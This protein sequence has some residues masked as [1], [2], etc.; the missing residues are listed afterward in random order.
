MA[1][2]PILGAKV[3]LAMWFVVKPG[4]SIAADERGARTRTGVSG[5]TEPI[6][7]KESTL[8]TG[9]EPLSSFGAER[10]RRSIVRSLRRTM[11]LQGFSY[12]GW[13]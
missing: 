8:G 10:F 7:P 2:P 9:D 12:V 11:P 4:T 5:L 6:R 3:L 13:P 1:R